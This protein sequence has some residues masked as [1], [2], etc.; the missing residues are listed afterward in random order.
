VH[1]TNIDSYYDFLGPARSAVATTLITII[2]TIRAK[3]CYNFDQTPADLLDPNQI[4]K[5]LFAV[6]VKV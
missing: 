4:I 2:V 6:L 3:P 1:S 5:R